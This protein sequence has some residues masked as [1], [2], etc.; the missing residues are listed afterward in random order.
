MKGLPKNLNSKEDYI[1][2]KNNFPEEYWK[3]EFQNL[4]D[5]RFGW[6]YVEDLESE[7]G[8]NDDT[9]KVV[10]DKDTGYTQYELR[11]NPDAKIFKL[12]FTVEEVEEM[13]KWN[14]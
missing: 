5:N 2:A 6:F 7:K 3:K 4:L 1:Y 8:I 13:L 14:G 10:E 9:H 11:E 12:G